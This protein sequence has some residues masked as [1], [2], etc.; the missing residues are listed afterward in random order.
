VEKQLVSFVL[1]KKPKIKAYRL[2]S[3]EFWFLN[4]CLKEI[5]LRSTTKDAQKE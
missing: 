3:I 5:I 2:L 4:L 1:K